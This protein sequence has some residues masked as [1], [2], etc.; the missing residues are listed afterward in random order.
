MWVGPKR[1]T[2]FSVS[3][4]KEVDGKWVLQDKYI[5]PLKGTGH[6]RRTLSRQCAMAYHGPQNTP[7]E[8]FG[9]ADNYDVSATHIVY[10]TKDPTLNPAFHT[11]QNV[12]M[13]LITCSALQTDFF[14]E[15]LHGFVAR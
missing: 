13:I 1:S 4:K 10:T 8:P 7:V 6:V 12:G 14:F 9:G 3:L 5:A 11:R 15:D 2:L